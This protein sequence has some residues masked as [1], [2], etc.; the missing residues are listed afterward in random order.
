LIPLSYTQAAGDPPTSSLQD[1]NILV[2][3]KKKHL[4]IL[5]EPESPPPNIGRLITVTPY[6]IKTLI[7]PLVL[8]NVMALVV[9]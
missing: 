8:V 7:L 5:D 6:E 9:N 1:D 4:N 3:A 2:S